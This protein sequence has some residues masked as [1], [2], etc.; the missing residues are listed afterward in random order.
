MEYFDGISLQE[1][2]QQRVKEERPLTDEEAR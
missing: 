1:Y 2:I